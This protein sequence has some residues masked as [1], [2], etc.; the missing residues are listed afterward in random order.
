[1]ALTTLKRTTLLFL[2]TAA[3]LASLLAALFLLPQQDGI[4]VFDKLSFGFYPT[5]ADVYTGLKRLGID[6]PALKP[7]E[8]P[9]ELIEL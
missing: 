2:N 6:Y 3:L 4:S 7:P 5:G 8:K 9:Q 1:M